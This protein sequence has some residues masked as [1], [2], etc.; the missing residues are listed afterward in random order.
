MLSQLGARH[1]LTLH[2]QGTLAELEMHRLG[3]MEGARALLPAVVAGFAA[4]L[5][6]KHEFTLRFTSALGE[7]QSMLRSLCTNTLHYL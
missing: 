2:A 6:A 4:Q 1:M 7:L 5:G 3:Q